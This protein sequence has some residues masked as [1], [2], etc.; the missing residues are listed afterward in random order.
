MISTSATAIAVT[1]G[2]SSS[3][4]SSS[5]RR[6]RGRPERKAKAKSAR[7]ADRA[8]FTKED[9]EEAFDDMEGRRIGDK[10]KDKYKGMM[11]QIAEF[12]LKNRTKRMLTL[13]CQIEDI[14]N[15]QRNTSEKGPEK[16][17]SS[18]SSCVGGK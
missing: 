3:S 14:G 4:S 15:R 8:E 9:A 1:R 11:A 5:G 10:C 18:S 13:G 6:N 2:N 17:S 12:G 7:K 16:R